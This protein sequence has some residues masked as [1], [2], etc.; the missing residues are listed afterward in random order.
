MRSRL[1]ARWTWWRS[2]RRSACPSGAPTSASGY[3]K[4]SA[5]R[6]A[7]PG[8]PVL[9]LTATATPAVLR[10]VAEQ[11]RLHEPA[12]FVS[13]FNR[14]NLTYEVRQKGDAGADLRGALRDVMA[15]DGC[16]IVF[17]LT[18]KDTETRLRAL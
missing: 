5:L 9:A 11:L 17:V 18:Q 6:A 1:A 12:M 3:R 13:T 15:G 16:A 2:T 14:P 10:D 7:L 4:R 8:V